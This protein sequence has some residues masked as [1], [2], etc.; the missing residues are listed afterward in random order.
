MITF[1]LRRITYKASPWFIY[2]FLIYFN[3]WGDIMKDNPLLKNA[4]QLAVSIENLCKAIDRTGNSNIIFQIRKSSS[5]VFANISEA[6][7]PQ[8]LPDMLSKFK[9][10]RKECVETESWLKLLYSNNSID[11]ETFKKYRNL[12]GRIQRMLTSSCITIENKINRTAK[13]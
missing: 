5:S 13:K 6:Q 1:R 4:E 9:I 8:S 7:Y 11:E 10:A 2:G 12:C 3:I